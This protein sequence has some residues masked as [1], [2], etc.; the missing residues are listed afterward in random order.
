MKYI[1]DSAVSATRRERGCIMQPR[2]TGNILFLDLGNG[3][4]GCMFCN[5]SLSC[6]LYVINFSI[7]K[8]KNTLGGGLTGQQ[9]GKVQA[10]DLGEGFPHPRGSISIAII[11]N[12]KCHLSSSPSLILSLSLPTPLHIYCTAMSRPVSQALGDTGINELQSLPSAHP[13][14]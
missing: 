14:W 3:Q 8:F 13:G 7:L 9:D 5:N 1:K 4:T 6:T 12:Q 11:S 10:L 2:D